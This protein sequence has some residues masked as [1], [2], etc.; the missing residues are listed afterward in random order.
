MNIDEFLQYKGVSLEN[1]V[2]A[3]KN[4]LELT[5]GDCL[6]AG[7]SLAEGT[8]NEFSD[9]DFFLLT[10]RDDLKFHSMTD[11]ALVVKS[12][13][14][15]VR[16]MRFATVNEVTARFRAWKGRQRNPRTA[17]EFTDDE[18]KF[19]HRVALGIPV[20]GG[21]ILCE[22]KK[23]YDKKSLC[24]HKFA[25]ARHLSET[26]RVDIVGFLQNR[27]YHS[28]FFSSL[29]L[30]GLSI[31]GLLAAQGITNPNPKW[32]SY[33]LRC[34]PD[35]WRAKFP[36]K[37]ISDSAMH[38]YISLH[39][40]TGQVGFA[41]TREHALK[42][43]AFSRSAFLL[44]EVALYGEGIGG[45]MSKRHDCIV[46]CPQSKRTDSPF[47]DLRIDVDVRLGVSGLELFRI[48]HEQIPILLPFRFLELIG[49]FD[50]E[51]T[52]ADICIEN[53]QLA[54]DIHALLRCVREEA[55]DEIDSDKYVDLQEIFSKYI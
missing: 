42:I 25:W 37:P 53:E 51:T 46:Y 33:Y 17:F 30:L 15:D 19:M 48:N 2:Q 52:I 44:A 11:I 34:L 41:A 5:A 7:G 6:F 20:Y 38:Q 12:C 14:I 26:I 40:G 43:S 21:E 22:L 49:L 36:P 55:L 45:Q 54:E 39:Q 29:E 10:D 27:D 4:E 31:D 28:A 13:L 16:V 3:A 23:T 9:L 24:R 1:V 47:P 50:G 18:R 8:G 35:D 32:R